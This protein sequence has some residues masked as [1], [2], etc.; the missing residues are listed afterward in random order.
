MARKKKQFTPAPAKITNEIVE[1]LLAPTSVGFPQLHEVFDEGDEL[2]TPAPSLVHPS[3]GKVIRRDAEFLALNFGS[4]G[5]KSTA[6]VTNPPWLALQLHLL[7]FLRAKLKQNQPAAKPQTQKKT[8]VQKVKEGPG[9]PS[10][11]NGGWETMKKKGKEVAENMMLVLTTNKY[12]VLP[13]E[14]NAE[15]NVFGLSLKRARLHLHHNGLLVTAAR[16]RT[17]DLVSGEL[18]FPVQAV[19]LLLGERETHAGVPTTEVAFG[20]D[21]RASGS[22]ARKSIISHRIASLSDSDGKRLKSTGSEDE[23]QNQ[24]ANNETT[25]GKGGEQKS[26][27]VSDPSKDYI[28]VRARRGQA[29]DSHSL[30]ERRFM[31]NILI[32]DQI[33]GFQVIGKALVLDEIINYIQSLQR[34]VE[35]LSMKLAVNTRTSPGIEGFPSKDEA[36]VVT[37]CIL[38]ILGLDICA[39]TMNLVCAKNLVIDKS[40]QTT[41]IE[42]IR[43]AQHFI[44]IEN[45]YFLGSS[46]AWPNYKNAASVLND[47]VLAG[48]DH[49]IP[50]ELALKI[51]SKIRA[52]ERFAVYVVIP[53]WPKG[54]PTSA[55][56]QEILF[57]QGETMQM[58]YS[59]IAQEIKAMNLEDAYSIY[60]K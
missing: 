60:M 54:V 19:L 7:R 17:V 11:T 45:K 28:Y 39:D 18:A 56:V 1:S 15:E 9:L 47:N 33:P 41:Y 40:I 6:T 12:A 52:K 26:K 49:L 3:A 25:S 22:P 57:W 32:P 42:A 16:P 36:S 37:E 21:D 23:N 14:Q 53:I 20:Q 13:E 8:W 48:A 5:P 29:T 4:I 44:Y 43:S 2:V 55:S 31:I 34:Q 50:M 58:M 10:K 38:K 24:R 27:P 35:F 30:A 59:K 51:V 46:Y